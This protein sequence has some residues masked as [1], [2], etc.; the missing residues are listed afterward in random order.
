MTTTKVYACIVNHAGMQHGGFASVPDTNATGTVEAF[1]ELV[2]RSRQSA[3]A[4]IDLGD[5]AVFGPWA[6]Y[7]KVPAD[8]GTAT[9]G[10]ARDPGS[11]L[12]GAVDGA[13][14]SVYFLVRIA[15][16]PPTPATGAFA[17]AR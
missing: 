11:S 8:V 14:E 13:W 7:E 10:R 4:N 17:A 15:A 6:P 9:S 16:P 2:K 5:M 3:C 12:L 1:M